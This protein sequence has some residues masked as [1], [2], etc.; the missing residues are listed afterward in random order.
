MC[1]CSDVLWTS[2]KVVQ[3]LCRPLVLWQ[4]M[5]CSHR[6]SSS[7]CTTN[8]CCNPHIRILLH[9]ISCLAADLDGKPDAICCIPTPDCSHGLSRACEWVQVLWRSQHQLWARPLAK[10]A[11]LP[12]R[13]WHCHAASGCLRFCIHALHISGC[14]LHSGCPLPS[15][16]TLHLLC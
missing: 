5:Q 9:D 3:Q 7:M 8:S 11:R 4:T 10:L 16:L 12:G 2:R 15:P 13:T 1:C 14:C 6:C